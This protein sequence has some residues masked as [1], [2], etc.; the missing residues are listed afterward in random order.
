[1]QPSISLFKLGRTHLE[2]ASS[3]A[4]YGIVSVPWLSVKMRKNPAGEMVPIVLLERHVGKRE[5]LLK[6]ELIPRLSATSD[7]VGILPY[8]QRSQAV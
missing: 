5:L 2:Q 3:S 4:S 8:E 1:M 7:Y 6:Q